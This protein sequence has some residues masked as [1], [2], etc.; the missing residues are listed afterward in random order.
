MASQSELRAEITAKIIDAIENKNLL[1][2]R[3]P[4]NQGQQSGRHSNTVSGKAYSGINP[5]LLEVHALKHGFGSRWWATFNQWKALGANVSKRPSHVKPGEWGASIVFFKPV[6]KAAI[7]RDTGEEVQDT[8]LVMRTY[9]VFNADQVEGR[10]ERFQTP[11]TPAVVTE[12]DPDFGPADNLIQA[13]GAKI[14]HHGGRAFYQRPTPED[15]WPN[16]SNGDCIVLPLKETFD[17][18]GAYYE[19]AFHELGHWAEV[20]TGWDHRKHGYS[21]GELVAEMSA[22]FVSAELGVP[23]GESLENHAA[24]LKSWLQ[25]MKGDPSFLFKASTQASKVTDFLLGFV[26]KEEETPE[27]VDPV[28]VAG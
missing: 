24:Y 19:T 20:R 28:A 7:D 6:K 25:G 23:Q 17:L 2:W 21:M 13:T 11:K 12:F 22:S 5:L 8:F 3:R 10:I 26:R 1:P 18:P 27:E 4:W 14:I 16:H 15:S 9:V